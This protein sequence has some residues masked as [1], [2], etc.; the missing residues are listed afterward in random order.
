MRALVAAAHLN[1]LESRAQDTTKELARC[2]GAA[3]VDRNGT[4]V[5][6]DAA[7]DLIAVESNAVRRREFAARWFDAL[8]PCDDLRAARLDLLK[9][10]ARDLGFENLR[11][12][13]ED[14][15]GAD[16]GTLSASARAFLE[17]TAPVYFSR[18]AQW[19]TRQTPPLVP[20]AL[21]YA[22]SLHFERA[23]DL[24]AFFQPRAFR[25]AYRET[26]AGLGISIETQKNLHVDDE[27]RALKKKQTSC[28]A[29]K[30]PVDVRL[31]VDSTQM[32]A[33]ALR[34][35]LHEMGRA[36]A[37]AWGSE[38][39]AGRYPEF[40][41]APDGA[42][43]EGYGFL[44]S[45]LLYD[46][47][48]IGE[49]Q[50]VRATEAN[51]ITRTL[52]L[53]EMHAVRRS[54]AALV[55]ALA[56]SDAPDVRAE[57]LAERYVAR[58]TEATG[59]RYHAATRL[60]HADDAFRAAEFLRARLFSV[61]LREYLRVRHGRRWYG[62]RGAGQELIDI[63]NTASRYKVEELARL[64]GAAGLSFDFLADELETAVGV[65]Q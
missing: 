37:F 51:G 27:A 63:W 41:Y 64:V 10:S 1:Y 52:A 22:D 36:Q 31:V 53:L 17:R 21:L 30:P 49:H 50:G 9:E 28:F 46:D 39:Q 62:A 18:L 5:A 61:S 43:N 7:A 47:A 40:V 45:G 24:D 48:W 29:L 44:F 60:L 15:A 35:A 25:V 2:A 19:A 26:M 55:D 42:T 3:R 65:E 38:E 23:A 14:L 6:A 32:G 12:L 8:P 20:G 13:Y 4:E 33:P 57:S 56:L 11:A 59:F 16:L 54:C 34:R 58:H